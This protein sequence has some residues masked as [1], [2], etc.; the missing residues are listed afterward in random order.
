MNAKRLINFHYN[1][2]TNPQVPPVYYLPS[3]HVVTMSKV[4]KFTYQNTS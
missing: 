2:S 4:L 3:Q 1:H